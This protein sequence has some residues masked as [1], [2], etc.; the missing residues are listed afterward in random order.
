MFSIIIQ[1]SEFDA[2]SLLLC[3]QFC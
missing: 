1:N 3:C 2:W